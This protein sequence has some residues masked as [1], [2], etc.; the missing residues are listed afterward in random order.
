MDTNALAA[1]E[2]IYIRKL[3]SPDFETISKFEYSVSIV[4]PHSDV[5]R[6]AELY[7][8]T[9]M[10]LDD[11]G[12]VAIV[13]KFTNRMVGTSQYYRSAPCIHGIEIGYLIHDHNSSDNN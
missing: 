2:S 5:T 13:E 4:E 6:L 7:A 8:E 12:A 9:S 1:S 10:W 11:S 3:E